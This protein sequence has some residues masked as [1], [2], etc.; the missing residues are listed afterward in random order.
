MTEEEGGEVRTL[1]WDEGL[2]TWTVS[3]GVSSCLWAGVMEWWWVPVMVCEKRA[4]NNATSMTPGLCLNSKDES[5]DGLYC[6]MDLGRC[7]W[8]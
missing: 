3:A 8:K 7:G 6:F 5:R 1:C 2:T 4:R